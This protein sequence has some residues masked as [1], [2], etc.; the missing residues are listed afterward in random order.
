VQD[1]IIRGPGPTAVQSRL[2]YLLSG[3]V[4]THPSGQNTV[5]HIA[6]SLHQE[7]TDLKSY[8]DIETIGI[9]DNT[10][11]SQPPDD[12]ETY[13]KTHLSTDEEGRNIAA[14]P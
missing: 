12:F 6:T 11:D 1:R 5:L 10:Q 14:L 13:R 2:G 4:K 7:D 9:K 3:P 8:W